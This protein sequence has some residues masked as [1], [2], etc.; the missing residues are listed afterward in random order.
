MATPGAPAV[1]AAGEKLAAGARPSR[2]ASGEECFESEGEQE[3]HFEAD[4][5]GQEAG[6]EFDVP[7]SE[8]MDQ[9]LR[10]TGS[11]SSR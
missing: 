6:S 3:R 2:A 4:Q 8:E 10:W 11:C 9:G 5:D 7:C 1:T